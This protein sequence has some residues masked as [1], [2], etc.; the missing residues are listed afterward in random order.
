MNSAFQLFGI[1]H[2]LILSAIP[3]IAGLLVRALNKK[4]ERAKIFR[5]RLAT[6]LLANELVWY[7]YCLIRGWVSFPYGLPLN[8]CDIVVWLTIAAA[9]T[10]N[11]TLV[12]LAYYWGVS[13]SL[14]AVL[15]P[16]LGVPL[17]SYPGVYFFVA[18]CG[19]V[20]TIIF[21][22]WGK[23]ATPRKGSAW[24]ALLW[25]NAYAVLIGAYNAIFQTNYFYLCEKPGSPTLLD[26]MGPWPWYILA[27]E[28]FGVGA[29]W[30]LWLPFRYRVKK[31]A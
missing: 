14:M 17:A 3:L 29:F 8:L 10:L 12:E 30:L 19:V 22:V 7:S 1:S 18:H 5:I 25:L 28:L 4:H 15:T 31:A 24:K 6:F 16:D 20:I 2:I 11:P 9:F 26:Y 27:G 21:I 13:G 23:L